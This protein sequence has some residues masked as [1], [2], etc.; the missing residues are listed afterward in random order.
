MFRVCLAFT[1]AN[2][3]MVRVPVLPDLD[4]MLMLLPL[5]LFGLTSARLRILSVFLFSALTTYVVL[6]QQLSLRVNRGMADEPQHLEGRVEGLPVADGQ[7]TRFVFRVQEGPLTGRRL[8]LSWFRAAESVQAGES[9]QLKIRL[10][11]PR[12]SLNFELFDYE[13][14]LFVNRIHGRGYV[15]GSSSPQ[16]VAVAGWS[17]D[18]LREA[19]RDRL[20]RI[21]P[22]AELATFYAL[23]LG[24]TSLLGTAHWTLLNE[25]GTT[26][27]LIVSGLHAGLIASLTFGLLRL[28]GVSAGPVA[29]ISILVTAC[30]ALV[31]GWGLPV[32]RALVMCMVVVSARAMGRQL[33]LFSQFFLALVAVLLMD[34]LATLT[35][36]F[37]LSFG[38]VFMLLYAL[39]A[40]AGSEAGLRKW[41]AAGLASQ[42][43]VYVGLAPVLAAT[44]AKVSLMSFAVNIVAIPWVSLLLV[45]MLLSGLVCLPFDESLATHLLQIAGF[46]VHL[47]WQFL[48]AV[49]ETNVILPIAPQPPWLF[50]LAVLGA[51]VLLSPRGLMP[52]WPGIFL[53]ALIFRPVNWPDNQEL[54]LTFLDVGQGLSVLME[55]AAGAAVY[56]TGPKLGDR[57]SA[58]RQIVIPAIRNGGFNRLDQLV[59]SHGDNDHAGGEFDIIQALPVLNTIRHGNCDRVWRLGDVRFV[60]FSSEVVS[61]DSNDASCLLMINAGENSVL[62]TGDIEE[63]AELALAGMEIDAMTV[64]SSPHHGSDSS[65]SPALLNLVRPELVVVSAGYRNR[66]NH[67][68]EEILERYRRRAI[69]VFNTASA[70]AVRFVF[71]S[72]GYSVETARE[73]RPAVWRNASEYQGR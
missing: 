38:A 8:R 56:D 24:D 12:G 46:L 10:S 4:V 15:L 48:S 45:P 9:W 65:S 50:L 25:T 7:L 6:D 72:S 14:W 43:V 13:Q 22:E 41:A 18:G 68:D 27:L 31:A 26:H 1:A 61:R 62:L 3:M 59:I 36:G 30:Y 44:M 35:N 67:P 17:I 71:H 52:R 49:S 23:T 28:A 54:R 63:K 39:T 51:L 42:W 66:F 69:R 58:A 34:P 40:R 60:S 29:L 70:G 11:E 32:Q 37:W 2:L 33:P 21:V 64:I 73:V 16:R 47:L 20:R 57:F 5:V 55:T 53:L 19:I